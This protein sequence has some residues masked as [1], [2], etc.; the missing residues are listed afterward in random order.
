[1]A[2]PTPKRPH[3]A[4]AAPQTK[5]PPKLEFQAAGSKWLVENQTV[6]QG[7]VQVNIADLK[8]TVYIYGCIGATISVNGETLYNFH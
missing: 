4:A 3:A 2:K 5:G 7:L 1:M 8:E 6:E